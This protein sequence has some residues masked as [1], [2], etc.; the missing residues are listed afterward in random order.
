MTQNT[1]YI[2]ACSHIGNVRQNNQDNFFNNGQSRPLERDNFGCNL[3]ISRKD[4]ILLA[5]CDGMGGMKFGERASEIACE[6]LNEYYCHLKDLKEVVFPEQPDDPGVPDHKGFLKTQKVSGQQEFDASLN[7]SELSDHKYTHNRD[8]EIIQMI[9]DANLKICKASRELAQRMGSTI[10]LWEHDDGKFRSWNV[11][12]SRAYLCRNGRLQQLSMDHTE[13]QSMKAIDRLITDA[14]ISRSARNTLTQH[15]GIDPE[16]F[17]IEPYSSD[18]ISS[19]HG[20]IFLLCSDGLSGVLCDEEIC[21]VLSDANSYHDISLKVK[22]L[23]DKTLI[24][25]AKDN[26]TIVCLEVG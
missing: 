24:K 7:S 1:Y 19:Q 9:E 23:L 16:E 18:W 2:S 5:V 26:I 10:V 11:G 6:V 3:K 17:M 22:A 14:E 15:L 21:S 20:D 4:T 13:A 8:N 12:D 25:G